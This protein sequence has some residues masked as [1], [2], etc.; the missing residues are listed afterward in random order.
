M[1]RSRLLAWGVLALMVASFPSCKSDSAGPGDS[2]GLA[3]ED[4]MDAAGEALESIGGALMENQAAVTVEVLSNYITGV[5]AQPAIAPLAAIARIPTEALGSTFVFDTDLYEYVVDPTLTGAPEDGVRFL[6]YTVNES[7]FEIVLPLSQIGH[8]D[9]RDLTVGDNLDARHT[10]VIG[11]ATM[12]TFTVAGTASE[13][14]ADLTTSGTV[15]VGGTSAQFTF[16]VEVGPTG[17]HLVID[18]TSATYRL[19][20]DYVRALYG[21]GPGSDAIT[22]SESQSGGRVEFNVTWDAAFMGTGAVEF[23]DVIVADVS[24]SGGYPE[25]TPRAGSGLTEWDGL[26]L[27]EGYYEILHL[28]AFLLGMT[29]FGLQNAGIDWYLYY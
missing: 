13:A 19:Q 17:E 15:S 18:A 12:L 26:L 14:G 1:K 10:V 2:G 29:Q 22:L 21:V 7:T 27:V 6:L 16:D 11:G 8:I 23:N 9:I 24:G 5:T 3:A 20:W 25:V 4:F 28:E